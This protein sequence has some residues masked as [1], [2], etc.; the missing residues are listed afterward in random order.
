MI[1]DFNGW[2]RTQ[3]PARAASPTPASGRGSCP[4]SATARSTSTTSHRTTA[5]TASTRP[6]RSRSAP[7]CRRG[8]PRWSGTSTTTG[9]TTT[10]WPG[11]APGTPST[12]RSRS[13]RCTSGRGGARPTTGAARIPRSR[14][15]LVEHVTRL[16]FTH[17]ELLPVMEHPFYGS[18]G[19]QTTG[20]L[21][22]DAPLRRPRGLH[23]A[24]RPAAPGGH[25]RDPRLGAVALPERRARPRLL[26]RHAPVR[27]R[28]SAPGLPSRLG[29]RD[30]QLRPQRGAQLPDLE[31]LVL[32][33]RA[34]TPTACGSTRSR[35]CS[36][37][38]TRDAQGE[39]IPNAARR[40]REPRRDRVPAPAEPARVRDRTPTCR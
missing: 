36:T 9:A 27:A 17:V 33:R 12:R 40:S 15:A 31:R 23:G 1:G 8:P 19:Y 20:L 34:T 32:A 7:R 39:W 22:A 29:Q 14:P 13:T 26:R 3:P 18:W 10:G 30:L 6:T 28:R 25:R 24:R 16:G 11:A 38:T 35:R 37:S 21:R 2:D 5:A 4:A